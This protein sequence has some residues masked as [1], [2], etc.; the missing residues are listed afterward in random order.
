MVSPALTEPRCIGIGEIR[1]GLAAARVGAV[2]LGAVVH[3]QP[4]A[5]RQCG[6]VPGKCLDRL[7]S[8]TCVKRRDLLTQ[9]A[10]VLL[11]FAVC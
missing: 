6:R 8:K 4:L 7:R 3:E 9:S 11:V 5:D 1:V 10:D 2:A